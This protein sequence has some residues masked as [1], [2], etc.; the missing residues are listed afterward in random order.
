MLTQ[1]NEQNSSQ[2]YRHRTHAQPQLRLDQRSFLHC[3]V[4]VASPHMQ[5]SPLRKRCTWNLNPPTRNSVLGREIKTHEMSATRLE[6]QLFGTFTEQQRRL[7]N[8]TS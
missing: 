1:R 8:A 4:N 5:L 7:D 2:Q 6:H 3:Q